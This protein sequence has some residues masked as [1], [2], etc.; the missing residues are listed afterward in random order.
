[1]NQAD[2]NA[3]MGPWTEQSFRRF[4]FRVLLLQRRGM[5]HEQAER[6][7]NRLKLRDKQWDTRRNC[8]EC[9]N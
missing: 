9:S 2:I 4:A 6:C 3:Q 8:L 7:A 1:M 5:S